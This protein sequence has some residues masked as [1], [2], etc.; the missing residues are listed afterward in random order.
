MLKLIIF[1]LDGVIVDTEKNMRHSW[2]YVKKKYKI[3][4]NFTDYKKKIGLP[5]QDILEE[6]NIDK[7]KLKLKKRINLSH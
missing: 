3:N 7:I 2:E 6:L 4:K 1:D 5:F